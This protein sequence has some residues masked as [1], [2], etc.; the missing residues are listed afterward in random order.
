MNCYECGQPGHI[1]A[2]CPNKAWLAGPAAGDGRPAWCGTCDERSRHLELA[3][4]RVK[5]C[6]CHPESHKMLPQHRR[7]PSC[8]V[9]VASWDAAP[10]GKHALAA[11]PHPYIG[12]PPA[13]PKA[14]EQ[15]RLRQE[16]AAQ[17]ARSRLARLAGLVT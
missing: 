9:L 3:D 12:P 2:N 15:D 16:A 13:V 14:G 6:Q 5:R 17:V 7:C 4:G 11:I 8:R 10:C 1:K